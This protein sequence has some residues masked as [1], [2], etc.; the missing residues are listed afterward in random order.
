VV[1]RDDRSSRRSRSPAIASSAEIKNTM[2]WH[3][4]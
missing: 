1:L 2:R 3:Y 4:F